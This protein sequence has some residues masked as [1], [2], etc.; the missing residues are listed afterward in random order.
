MEEDVVSRTPMHVGL[1]HPRRNNDKQ[2]YQ[3]YVA[4]EGR[5]KGQIKTEAILSR[6]TKGENPKGEIRSIDKAPVCAASNDPNCGLE[7][8]VD[9]LSGQ[10]QSFSNGPKGFSTHGDAKGPKILMER[11]LDGLKEDTKVSL[12]PRVKDKYV[13][14]PMG[15]RHYSQDFSMGEKQTSS[16]RIQP[17]SCEG[18][19]EKTVGEMFGDKR[20]SLFLPISSSSSSFSSFGRVPISR[21]CLAKKGVVRGRKKG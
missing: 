13:P 6:L 2:Q 11:I 8:Q 12:G 14:N 17:K 5:S 3:E 7:Q 20:A 10:I 15:H 18:R 21:G 16:R 4:S 19:L 1:L 9:K